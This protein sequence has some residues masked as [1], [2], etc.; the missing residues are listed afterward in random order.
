MPAQSAEELSHKAVD[1]LWRAALDVVK[2][3]FNAMEHLPK[4]VYNFLLPIAASTCQG[5]FSTVMMFAGAMPALSNGASVRLWNQK[6]SPLVLLVLHMAPPQRGKSRLFQAVE[7][8][9]ETADE[10]VAKL[11]KNQAEELAA[12]LAPPLEG[13]QPPAELQVSTKSISLQSFTMTEF[14]YRCSVEF[15]QVEI[16]G[17]KEKR[18]SRAWF[19]QAFNLDECYEFLENIGLLGS[20]NDR[21]KASGAVHTHASTL[22]SLVQRGKTK[23]ATRTATSY[24]GSLAQHVAVSLLGNGH[25]AKLIAMERGLEGGHTAATRERFVFAV[26]ES[27]ARH[28]KV[29]KDLLRANDDLPAWT[30]LPLTSLQATIFRWTDLLNNPSHFAGVSVD[31]DS[32]DE[33]YPAVLPDGVKSRIRY[34][35]EANP[36]G[37]SS[38]IAV[39]CVEC[40]IWLIEPFLTLNLFRFLSVS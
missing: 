10:F 11:A 35:E 14:F 2:D 38:Q 32:E 1:A 39:S 22:N 9:F 40:C 6:A 34:V 23:R 26:D 31:E 4:E 16:G 20:R 19:G 27:V 5:M 17:R 3:N 12:K 15:P 37:V 13:V 18:T 24:E 30:W 8:L 33:G 25:P 28:D 21:D 36:E 7:L 29:P